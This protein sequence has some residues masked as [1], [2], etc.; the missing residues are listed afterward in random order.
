MV[1]KTAKKS[2]SRKQQIGAT[3]KLEVHDRFA[4]V[5]SPVNGGQPVQKP[6]KWG[7]LAKTSLLYGFITLKVL[8]IVLLYHIYAMKRKFST[9]RNSQK[10]KVQKTFKEDSATSDTVKGEI[11]EFQTLREGMLL[12]GCV[13]EIQQNYLSMSLPGCLVGRV[14]LVNISTKYTEAIRNSTVGELE[15]DLEVSLD[16]IF[17][18]GALFPCKVL[19]VFIEEKKKIIELSI[20][21]QDV[22]KELRLSSI[23]PKMVLHVAVQS[24]ED[25]GYVMDIGVK[26]VKGFLPFNATSGQK[27]LTIGQIIPASVRTLPSEMNGNVAWLSELNFNEAFPEIEDESLK[28][29]SLL[30][31][32]N[33]IAYITE[34]KKAFFYAKCM[35]FDACTNA[36]TVGNI[37]KK[38]DVAD[39]V[40]GTVLFIHPE[41]HMIYLHLGSKPTPNS[42]NNFFKVKRFDL[43]KNVKYLHSWHYRLFF[44]DCHG[45]AGFVKQ[46]EL[47][48]AGISKESLS[49]NQIV[50]KAR[51]V[52]LHYM[53]NLVHL[54]FTKSLLEN[55]I[56]RPQDTQVGDIYEATVIEHTSRGMLVKVCISFTGL[57]RLI[58]ISDSFV[59]KPEKLHPVGSK[60]KCRA[61]SLSPRGFHHFTCKESL[62][63][64][65]SEDILKS[66]EQAQPGE[67]YKGV[68]V[69]KTEAHIVVLFFNNVKGVVFSDN[70]TESFVFFVGQT[71]PCQVLSCD[72]VQKKLQ[73]SLKGYQTRKES[74][75]K[76]MKHLE[77]KKLTKAKEKKHLEPEKLVKAIIKSINGHH[78]VI[79]LEGDFLG[80]IHITELGCTEE[81]KKPL[82]KFTVGKQLKVHVFDTTLKKSINFLAVSHRKMKIVYE[83]SFEYPPPV[84]VD[85]IFYPG[86]SVI[87]FVKEIGQTSATIWLSPS[88]LGELDYLNISDN[89]KDLRKLGKKL[90][91]GLSLA[92]DILEVKKNP[93]GKGGGYRIDLSKHENLPIIKAGHNIIG[94]VQNATHEEGLILKLPLGYTGV[95]HLTDMQDV[96]SP[97]NTVLSK[98]YALRFIRC[99]VLEVNHATK[100]CLL[101]IRNSRLF[102]YDKN[103]LKD[104]Q[105]ELTIK[106]LKKGK[107][108]KGY[109]I[110][111]E[112]DHLIVNIGRNLNGKVSFHNCSTYD[113]PLCEFCQ[114]T[115]QKYSVGD[116]LDVVIQRVAAKKNLHF[117]SLP[118]LTD[119]EANQHRRLNITEDINWNEL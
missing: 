98:Y 78:L 43:L 117:L 22:N 97:I 3:P 28:L 40:C 112:D 82:T 12:L 48:I 115:L 16:S 86:M 29:A 41:T 95:V 32:T 113:C 46:N 60:I 15:E 14:P 47:E 104:F 99:H 10:G 62:L 64:L 11:L 118:E 105:P 33:V 8:S 92:V 81:N 61:V 114:N 75:S 35:D 2:R 57:V 106:D 13:I 30:P 63:N 1:R 54:S 50:P 119:L 45:V 39:K 77:P 49:K 66:Y 85:K 91:V 84:P 68:I 59:T 107:K 94:R 79:L 88:Q 108:V 52:F 19:R 24:I 80:R 20:N 7:S 31:G 25:H 26:D 27:N 21:P 4:E 17:E 44:K 55:E 96:F 71:V 72:P 38:L 5:V 34:V 67:M 70:F 100:F 56:F 37:Y 18:Q 103:S 87:G 76:E 89:P 83:C 110:I 69:Q 58:H 90:R 93:K 102:N 42:F 73:L 109:I 36:L 111:I 65:P 74:K 53:D 23:Y 6:G 101:S 51:V 9:E 116:V